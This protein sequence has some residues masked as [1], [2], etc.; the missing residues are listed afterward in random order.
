[1]LAANI[2]EIYPNFH[3]QLKIQGKIQSYID[4][5]RMCFEL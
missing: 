4:L 2:H 3:Y 5:P 1:M